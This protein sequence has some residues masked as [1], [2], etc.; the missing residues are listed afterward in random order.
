MGMRKASRSGWALVTLVVMLSC[1][2]L[3]GL[4][5]RP[6]SVRGLR[7]EL[8][9]GGFDAPVHVTA[10]G[11]GSGRLFVVEKAGRIRIVRDGLVASEPFLD[12]TGLVESRGNEQ[13]LL[14]VA[15]HPAYATNGR[16]YLAY[17]DANGAVVLAGYRVSA[18]DPDRADPASAVPLLV[19]PK[20]F[21]DH[22][23]GLVLFGPDGYLYAGIGDGG[24]SAA[25]AGYAQ[26][27]ALLLGKL[28]RLD[29][30]R[31]AGDRPYG[32]PP[33]NP[34]VDDPVARPEVWVSGLRNPWRFAFDPTTDDLFIADVGFHRYEE[35]SVLP[36]GTGGG[37][38]LGWNRFE[39]RHCYRP[40]NP[41]CDAD[42]F[43]LPVAEY[44][45]PGCSAIIG[46]QV[47]RGEAIPSLVGTYLYA[48]LC[49]GHLRGLARAAA[50]DWAVS[51]PIATGLT[52]TSFGADEAGELYVTDL[53]GGLYRITTFD[54]SDS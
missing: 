12:I 41:G 31:A 52:P 43:V 13:G 30:D 40:A 35:V 37:A 15:F 49:S 36:A 11:D 29:V 1:L 26:D 6:P 18:A 4:A 7:L 23:G 27:R 2:A 24:T 54:R 46:G 5:D 25:A 32:I 34:F 38:N 33:D 16:F 21:A 53:R 28:L 10:A 9:A 39:G 51:G 47:Y 48:D 19:V 50:G 3:A 20:P 17:T 42:G 8:I 14:S 45:Q 44:H 22:N